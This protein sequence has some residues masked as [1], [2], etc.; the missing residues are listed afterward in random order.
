M[1]RALLGVALVAAVLGLLILT[2]S[3]RGGGAVRPR[4]PTGSPPPLFE[5]RAAA[6]GV[7]WRL[8]RAKKEALTILE[9]M[10]AGCA[11]LDVDN[12]GWDDLFLVGQDGFGHT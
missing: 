11:V 6:A 7:R 8:G 3:L 2:R 12:D 10:G 4:E 9:V 1:P 5:D